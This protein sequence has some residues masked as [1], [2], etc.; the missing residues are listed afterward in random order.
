MSKEKKRWDGRCHIVVPNKGDVMTDVKKHIIDMHSHGLKDKIG[1]ELQYV[2]NV[3]KEEYFQERVE[4]FYGIADAVL[5][6]KLKIEDS[7]IFTLKDWGNCKFKFHKTKDS[8]NE[9]IFRVIECDMNGK[10]PEDEGCTFPFNLQYMD[11]DWLRCD[12]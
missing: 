1:T 5:D 9:D 8:C 11:L 12:E 4:M 7:T 6:G 3:G 10:F 2:L